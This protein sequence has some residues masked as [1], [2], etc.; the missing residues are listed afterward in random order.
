M[1]WFFMKRKENIVFPATRIDLEQAIL[2]AWSTKEDLQLLYSN[3]DRMSE[4]EVQ[5]T[6]LGIIELHELRSLKA[7]DLF[8]KLLK[9]L[10]NVR[11]ET[12]R[13]EE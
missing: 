13:V 11:E 5:N 8:E 10:R 2:A 7:F 3:M 12:K 4:D 1:V 9:E 6:I